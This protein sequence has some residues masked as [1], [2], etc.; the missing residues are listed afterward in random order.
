MDTNNGLEAQN[1]LLKYTF[2]PR[3]KQKVTLSN[4]ITILIEQYLPTCKQKYLFQNYKQSSQYRSYKKCVPAYLHDRPRGVV[5]H[6]LDRKT[7]SLKYSPEAVSDV[8]KEEGV[9]E[10]EKPAGG[11]HTVNF[12]KT[13][14]DEMPS[15]TCR[16]WQRY[17]IPCKHFLQFF[18]LDL[19]GRGKGYLLPINRAPTCQW[20]CV[21]WI[22][23][24]I[25]LQVTVTTKQLVKSLFLIWQMILLIKR[26]QKMNRQAAPCLSE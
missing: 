5:L 21:P 16:D 4:I 23:I 22:S 8:D 14:Q 15:C 6:C 9:F 7:K 25:L 24:F 2:L 13:A 3:G 11:R 1:K 10:V 26:V 18:S 17:H 20:T 19:T 12:G